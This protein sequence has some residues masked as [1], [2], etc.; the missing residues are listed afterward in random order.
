MN[1]DQGSHERIRDY[2]A[3]INQNF[4]ENCLIRSSSDNHVFHPVSKSS[5]LLNG[6]RPELSV[7]LRPE[8][9]HSDDYFPWDQLVE[10]AQ[11]AEWLWSLRHRKSRYYVDSESKRCNLLNLPVDSDGYVIVYTDGACLKNGQPDAPAG[12]GVW[13]GDGHFL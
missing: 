5:W 11:D 8:I 1:G 6:L 12:I 13:F 7:E 4:N 10:A 9:D 3:Y 2:V